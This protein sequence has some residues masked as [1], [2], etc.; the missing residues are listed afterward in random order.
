MFGVFLMWFRFVCAVCEWV[1]L[2]WGWC[3]PC[4]WLLLIVLCDYIAQLALGAW[5]CLGVYS[6]CVDVCFRLLLIVA[7]G[8]LVVA[9]S[10]FGEYLTWWFL[11]WYWLFNLGFSA[12]GGGWFWYFVLVIDVGVVVD[13][14]M[15]SFSLCDL[16]IA[17]LL[18]GFGYGCIDAAYW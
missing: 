4:F 9:V 6:S 8:S 1:C 16:W 7:C 10:C 13:V 12:V 2:L 14:L 3:M 18:C 17:C 15:I 11:L 5:W